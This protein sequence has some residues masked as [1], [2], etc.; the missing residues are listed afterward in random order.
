M[1]EVLS[2]VLLKNPECVAFLVWDKHKNLQ[3][4]SIIAIVIHG[5]LLDMNYP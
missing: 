4:I 1:Q 3:S 2:M 5:A